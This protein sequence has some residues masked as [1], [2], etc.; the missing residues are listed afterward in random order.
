M[1]DWRIVSLD[2]GSVIGDLKDLFAAHGVDPAVP[3]DDF[4]VAESHD[5]VVFG[6]PSSTV[7]DPTRDRL[8]RV[9]LQ[10]WTVEVLPV[11][12]MTAGAAV[13]PRR[14]EFADSGELV[15]MDSGAL[16]AVLSVYH[17]GQWTQDP[18]VIRRTF[19]TRDRPIPRLA[20]M[21]MAD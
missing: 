17:D 20:E 11:P 16:P 2:N 15:L 19:G 4:P 6:P 14:F 8:L 1:T 13:F 18:A 9:D 3:I 5:S 10:T 12:E 7:I 21:T